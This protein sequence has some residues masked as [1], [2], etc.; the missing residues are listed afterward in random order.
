VSASDSCNRSRI[1]ERAEVVDPAPDFGKDQRRVGKRE[2]V[3]ESDGGRIAAPAPVFRSRACAGSDRV[4][5]D[6]GVS[7]EEVGTVSQSSA[8][9]SLADEMSLAAVPCVEV[10]LYSRFR[11]SIPVDSVSFGTS[12]SAWRW[13]VIWQNAG[14]RQP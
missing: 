12:N 3:R 8:A 7:A 14:T 11:Y 2:V 6:I 13:V 1:D 5:D 9:K 10:L 4:E